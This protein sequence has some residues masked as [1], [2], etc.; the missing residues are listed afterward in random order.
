MHFTG[1]VLRH[2][3]P[4]HFLW[5]KNLQCTIH[6]SH[7]KCIDLSLLSKCLKGPFLRPLRSKDD[8]SSWILRLWPRNFVIISAMFSCQPWKSKADLCMTNCY[9]ILIYLSFFVGPQSLVSNAKRKII[10]RSAL[11][12]GGW[13]PNFQSYL[14]NFEV[15]ASKF[16]IKCP[17]TSMASKMALPN[18]L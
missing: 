12:F 7:Q 8:Q 16:K 6:T 14:K 11:L 15:L 1:Y 13:Q 18:K 3:D 9:R 17:L 5:G 4:P 2:G 10:Q